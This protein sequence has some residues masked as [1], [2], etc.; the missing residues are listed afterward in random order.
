MKLKRWFGVLFVSAIFALLLIC[1]FNY[2]VDPFGVFGD[3]FINWHTFNF[4]NNPRIAKI[5]YLDNNHDKYNGYAIGGSKSGSINPLLLNEYYGDNTSFYSMLMYGGDFF[6]YEKTLQ[7]LVE[8]YSVDHIVIHMSMH[9]MSHYHEA[10]KEMNNDLHAKVLGEPL[11]PFYMKY[12]TLNLGYGTE[13][14]EGLLKRRYDPMESNQFI[15]ET[16]VYNKSERD[17]E[18]LGTLEEYLAKYPEFKNPLYKMDS[19]GAEENLKSL[20]RMKEYCESRGI[21]FMFIV[22]PTYE[23]EMDRYEVD[24]VKD[25]LDRA[26][27]ITPYWNFSGYN[28]ISEDPRYFYDPMHYRN[29]VG[30]MILAR[31]FGDKRVEVPEDFGE[32]RGIE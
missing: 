16:G 21:S 14:L 10:K 26:A 27:E 6:D 2:I 19:S 13:K 9:E 15:P 8:N 28:T 5:G 30:E 1:A 12:L 31:I 18:D 7:Y 23:K 22:A 3:K 11:L 29:N 24:G 20:A 25:F 4:V 32:Y 17:K